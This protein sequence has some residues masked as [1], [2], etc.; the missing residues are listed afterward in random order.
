MPDRDFDIDFTYRG[1]EAYRNAF[2]EAAKRWEQIITAD[3]PD[4]GRVD[5]IFIKARVIEIDGKGDFLGEAWPTHFRSDSGLPFKGI[6]ELDK[7]DIREMSNDGILT[8]VIMHEMG[9]V[10]GLGTLWDTSYF[11]FV[12]YKRGGYTGENALQEY[13]RLSGDSSATYVP[14]ETGGGR[15]T[16][17]YHWSED[18]FDDELMTGYVNG[19]MPIS[20]VT[21]GALEDLGYTV[22][23]AQ[24]EPYDL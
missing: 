16:A 18:V 11:D 19:D 13:R 3:L 2:E 24:A 23:Y 12:N 14:L 6:M 1:N 22:S 20:R 7:A 8:A 17:Y 9:H 10:L 5:D 15:G 4:V 21:I